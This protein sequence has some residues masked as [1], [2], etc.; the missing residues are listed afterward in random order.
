MSVTIRRLMNTFIVLFLAISGVAA[1]VQ[2]GNQ[3]FLNGPALAAGKYDPRQCP[4]YDQPVRGTI[5]DRNGQWLARSVR[6]SNSPCGYRREYFDA[7]LSPLLGFFT[8]NYGRQSTGLEASFDDQ[9]S[10]VQHGESLGDATSKLLHKP[11]YGS[12]I[13]L[14]IDDKIQQQANKLYD[15]K[16]VVYTSA[17]GVCQH[18]GTDPSG[19]LVVEDP[20]KGEIIAMVSRPYFDPNKINDPKYFQQLQ[21]DPDSP[22]LNRATQG[23]FRPGSTFKTM[24]LLA[25]LDTGTL[26]LDSQ[27]S[28]DEAND[29]V[30]NGQHFPWYDYQSVW[31]GVIPSGT[32]LTLQDG[33]AYSDNTIFARA[34]IQTGRDNWLSYLRKFGIAT[35]R[36]GSKVDPVPF[37]GAFAQSYAYPDKINGKPTDISDNLI[38]EEGYGQGALQITPLTMI[39]MDSAIAANGVLYNPHVTWKVV[40]HGVSAKDVLPKPSEVYGGGPVIR[41][42]T[43]QAVRQ[44][45]AAVVTSGT[46]YYGLFSPETGL[47]LK[48]SPTHE[49]GKTGTNQNEN[50]EPDAWWLSLAPNDQLPAANGAQAKY[51]IVLN[52]NHSG[53][54]ACQVFVA[55]DIYKALLHV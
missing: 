19:S 34:A 36:S 46:A 44:A 47:R 29:F 43:A 21:T 24:T 38:A 30:V 22:Q 5:Y 11:R 50:G 37:D 35:P 48:D 49:G 32:P 10:G 54:G 45:M 52:K 53:E 15:S 27:Y 23:L 25:A 20:N 9:L 3:A 41:P 26:S 33:F 16:A 12:D 8:Y 28:F 17:P 55:D 4:P 42:E 13:Y 2:I 7:S 40:P 51:T 31:T 39:E 6:D 14:T 18:P 1:Y